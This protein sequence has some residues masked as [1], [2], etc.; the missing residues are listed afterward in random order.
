MTKKE[1]VQFVHNKM[2]ATT[3][4]RILHRLANK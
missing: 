3:M 2:G 1:K 4:D